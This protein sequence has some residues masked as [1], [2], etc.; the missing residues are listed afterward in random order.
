MIILALMLRNI[1]W[2]NQNQLVV[3]YSKNQLLLGEKQT[4]LEQK[5]ISKSVYISEYIHYLLIGI[6][7]IGSRKE[8]RYIAEVI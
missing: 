4:F 2:K 3:S 7:K 8:N 6:T 5:Q 1:L